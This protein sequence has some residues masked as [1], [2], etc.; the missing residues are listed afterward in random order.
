M[1]RFVT[2]SWSVRLR[3]TGYA[4][5]AY[6]NAGS[7][8][9]VG[10]FLWWRSRGLSLLTHDEAIPP[11]SSITDGDGEGGDEPKRNGCRSRKGKEHATPQE[12]DAIFDVGHDENDDERSPRARV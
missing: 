5:T 10:G 7:A 6:C 8:A 1:R 9:L 3:R 12:G 11:N 2:L 4:L